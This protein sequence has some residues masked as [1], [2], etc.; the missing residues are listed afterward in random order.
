MEKGLGKAKGLC[1]PE[2]FRVQGLNFQGHK[3][4]CQ[5]HGTLVQI[6]CLLILVIGTPPQRR[7]LSHSGKC[8]GVFW[9]K[10]EI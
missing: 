4:G 6:L 1:K 10:P 9:G 5:K 2:S 7:A 8:G 3:A